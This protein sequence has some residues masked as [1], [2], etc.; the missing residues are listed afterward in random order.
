MIC[1]NCNGEIRP[2]DERC[3]RC[4]IVVQWEGGNGFWDMAGELRPEP[5]AAPTKAAE[6][7][8]VQPKP[9]AVRQPMKKKADPFALALLL[10]SVFLLLLL[11]AK[12]AQL[13]KAEK[14]IEILTK[15]TEQMNKQPEE[16]PLPPIP[17]KPEESTTP[18]ASTAP[19]HPPMENSDLTP[20][21]QR[22]K[23]D[24][25]NSKHNSPSPTS[26]EPTPTVSPSAELDKNGTGAQN[27]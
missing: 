1:K 4:G 14:E 2:S 19:T 15:K 3:P 26:A 6:K 11:F 7:P 18:T 21:G 5:K 27:G 13:R 12:S 9:P 22:K 23:A 16:E 20:A 24:Y 10:L 25:D 8:M 17:P